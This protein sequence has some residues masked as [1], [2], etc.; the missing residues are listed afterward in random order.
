[1][2]KRRREWTLA[3]LAILCCLI[4]V[5]N[6]ELRALLIL[7][8]ALSLELVLFLLLIQL[9]SLLPI[10]AMCFTRVFKWCCLSSFFIL[11][12]TVRMSGAILPVGKLCDFSTFLFVLSQNLWC[13]L[14]RK[15]RTAR[16]QT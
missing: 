10:M 5:L 7:V 8:E 2:N 16:L 3:D 1:M 15:P 6:P 12:G 13:P 14:Y 4:I 11:R 9:R